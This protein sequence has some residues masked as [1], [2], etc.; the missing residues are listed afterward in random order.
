V[1]MLSSDWRTAESGKKIGPCPAYI[2]V[3]ILY[4]YRERVCTIEIILNKRQP[5]RGWE[6]PLRAFAN[7]QGGPNKIFN[8]RTKSQ[9][10]F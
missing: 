6:K 10:T 8:E 7:T 9:T 4:I 1:P 5:L 2:P 3:F